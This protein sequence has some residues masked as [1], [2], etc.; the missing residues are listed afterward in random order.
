MRRPGKE[1]RKRG[2]VKRSVRVE[3]KSGWPSKEE[4]STTDRRCGSTGDQLQ[5]PSL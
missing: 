4:E 5:D 2:A 3:T 1:E